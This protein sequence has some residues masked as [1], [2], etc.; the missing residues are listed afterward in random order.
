MLTKLQQELADLLFNTKIEAKV[1][2]R[3]QNPDGTYY[4]EETKRPTSP[5]DFAQSEGEFAL[6]IHEVKPE[7]PLSPI[8]VSL[9]NLPEN[10]LEKIAQVLAKVKF[11]TPQDY[12]SGVPKA[13]VV[14]AQAYS[15]ASGIPFIDV[16]EKV[17]SN[18]DREILVKDGVSPD[19]K[20]NRLLVI[21]DVIAHGRSK[22][23]ALAAAKKAGFYVNMLVLIDREQGG[24]EQVAKE[25][26]RVYAAMKLTD[27]L[28]YY[29][30][31]KI[32]SQKQFDETVNYLKKSRI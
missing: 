5:I 27:I 13:A 8:Y 17:G 7:A 21:D 24:M 14:I 3:L 4:L 2:R 32:I 12:C 28:R 26:C 18:T 29:L 19:P 20:K 15:E 25:N 10:V 23:E 11:D 22:L 31:K 1:I 6:K 16:F 30:E 9:R